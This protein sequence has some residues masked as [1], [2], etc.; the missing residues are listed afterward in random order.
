MIPFEKLNKN[1][2]KLQKPLRRKEGYDGP[3]PRKGHEFPLKGSGNAKESDSLAQ[4]KTFELY[5]KRF[6]SLEGRI[7]KR[8]VN[9]FD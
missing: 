6:V 5:W 2:E 3:F 8:Y 7:E 9:I 4:K 1:R